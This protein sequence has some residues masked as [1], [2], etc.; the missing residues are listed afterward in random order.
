MSFWASSQFRRWVFAEGD[1][2]HAWIAHAAIDETHRA[3]CLHFVDFIKRIGAHARAP[4]RV[5]SSAV[6]FFRRFYLR[7]TF[8]QHAPQLVAPACL[9]VASKSEDCAIAQKDI[10]LAASIE[11]PRTPLLF[12]S[13]SAHEI[14]VLRTLGGDLMVWRT[15][16][17]DGTVRN[18]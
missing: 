17:C 16:C 18:A 7:H 5:L 9:L 3:L 13:L 15:E 1:A 8:A 2:E 12:A 14:I 11:D 10:L 6:V 4:S